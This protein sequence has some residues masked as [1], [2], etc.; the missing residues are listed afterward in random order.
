MPGSLVRDSETLK[1][2]AKDD[3]FRPR[4]RGALCLCALLF[5]CSGGERTEAFPLLLN[6]DLRSLLP[7]KVTVAT[8]DEPVL[9]TD[10]VSLPIGGSLLVRTTTTTSEEEGRFVLEV[11]LRVDDD[12]GWGMRAARSGDPINLG[13][14]GGRAMLMAQRYLI[15]SQRD[16]AVGIETRETIIEVAFTGVRVLETPP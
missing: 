6:D 12:E 1:G 7:V 4:R 3:S 15:T 9:R 8:L 2:K 16:A 13:S 10:T 11:N 14:E 5:A